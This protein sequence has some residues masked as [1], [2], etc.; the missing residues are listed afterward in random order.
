MEIVKGSELSNMEAMSLSVGVSKNQNNDGLKSRFVVMGLKMYLQEGSERMYYGGQVRH[1]L[2]ED[3]LPSMAMETLSK[4]KAVD[5][6]GKQLLD[7]K[8]GFVI[9]LAALKNSEEDYKRCKPFL[10]LPGATMETYVL[11]KG[12]CYANGAD[13]S[14]TFDKFK[15]PVVRES[16]DVLTQ[17]IA[18]IDGVP[19]YAP[20]MSLEARG[21]R[22]ESRFWR[23]P[24]NKAN[25]VQLN[26]NPNQQGGGNPDPNQGNGNPDPNAGN[27]NPNT[28][29]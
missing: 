20:G 12:P 10:D 26:G 15:S 4:Y 11:K 14:Q 8:G 17:V 23:T 2:F 6:Q 21:Q 13:G 1:V 29:F 22:L 28:P 25:T 24:V 16:I 7:Q 19:R 27:G 9:D 3:E 5:A 18:Y